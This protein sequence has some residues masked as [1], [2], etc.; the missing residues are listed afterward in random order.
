ME[1]SQKRSCIL[2][3]YLSYDYISPLSRYVFMHISYAI[4]MNKDKLN[5]HE[6]S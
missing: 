2:Q 4:S 3:N 6:Q 5:G 1:F